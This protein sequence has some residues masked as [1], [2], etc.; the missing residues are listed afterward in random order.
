MMP[1]A[2]YENRQARTCRSAR[3]I[4]DQQR[5]FVAHRFAHRLDELRMIGQQRLWVGQPR[6]SI[7]IGPPRLLVRRA[8]RWQAAAD[9]ERG[10]RRENCES[11]AGSSPIEIAF[12]ERA[13]PA[14]AAR[15]RRP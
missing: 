8:H 10:D 13:D 4:V 7:F 6:Q 5:R 1:R 14:G 15:F 11:H 3:A 12:A 2:L 9:N